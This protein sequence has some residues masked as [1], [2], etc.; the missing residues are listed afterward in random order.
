MRQNKKV[1]VKILISVLVI[2]ITLLL[3]YIVYQAIRL[4]IFHKDHVDFVP[5]LSAKQKI[6]DFR[7]LTRFVREVYPYNDAVVEYMGLD[8]IEAMEGEY[9]NKA[10][11]TENNMEFFRLVLEYSQRLR[12]GSGHTRVCFGQDF[13]MN[14]SVYHSYIYNIKRSAYKQTAY[15]GREATRLRW[16]AF[17]DAYV[18]YKDGKYVLGGEYAADGVVL[19]SGTVIASINGMDVDSYVRALQSKTRL[20]YDAALKKC[21]TAGLF[22]VDN[23]S[24]NSLSND[25]LSNDNLSNDDLSNDNLTNDNL[26]NE[27]AH[28]Y[29]VPNVNVSYDNAPEDNTS[30]KDYWRV[31]FLLEDGTV[32]S[33]NLNKL[34]HNA[35]NEA[36]NEANIG[37]NN[38][39]NIVIKPGSYPNAVCRELT[40]DAGYIKIFSFA[41][42]YIEDDNRVLQKFM[43]DSK[44]K[45]RKLIIDIRGNGGGEINYWSENLVRPLLSEPKTYVQLT[46]VKK[47]LFKWM[48]MKYHIYRWLFG[49]DLLQKDLNHII[50]VEEIQRD[51]FENNEWQVYRITKRFTHLNSF[52]FNGK[53][54]ILADRNTFSAADSFTAAAKE[55]GIASVIGTNTGGAGNC[56]ISPIDIALPNSGIIFTMDVEL[57]LNDN[58][59]PNHIFGTSPD[60][61][62][63]ASS[64]PTAN[65]SDFEVDDL[66]R[67]DWISSIVR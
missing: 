56:F 63:E 11:Q 37:A 3:S 26:T 2:S 18:I 33:V 46:A 59:E 42:Q 13:P 66:L 19:P 17:S 45:Y 44:G 7:Y 23:D 4:E 8:D 49:N 35:A 61:I 43:N 67:D 53:V 21:F 25:D 38:E 55:M 57:T 24:E 47:G 65:P 31:D 36:N 60:V 64:Y 16:N 54:Y 1:G 52:P 39:A 27:N 12:H 58:E 14:S 5:E 48:G 20:L 28:C 29:K 15:W 10:G 22:T 51:T 9:I 30:G 50:G 34:D 40:E 6:E 62:L 32:Y 41:G